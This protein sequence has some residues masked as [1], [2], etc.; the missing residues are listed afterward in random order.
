[1]GIHLIVDSCCDLTSEM[2]ASLDCDIAPLIVRVGGGCEYIDDGTVDIAALIADMAASRQGASSSCP[3]TEDYAVPMRGYDECFVVT[4][5]SKLSGSFNAARLAAEMV[6]EE[7]P[8]KKIHVFDS[9]SASSGEVHIAMYLGEKIRQ[10]LDF[11]TIVT[12]TEA[13]IDQ[14]RTLFVLEDFSNFIK[15][16]RIPKIA[17]L[18][19]SALNLCPIMGENGEGDI[20]LAA[21]ARGVQNSLHKL[22]EMVADMTKSRTSHSLRLV[23]AQCNCPQRAEEIKK[24]LL[25]KCEALREVVVVP[26]GALSAMYAGSGGVVLAF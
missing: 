17:G 13:F 22:V 20:K 24:N 7:F 12:Q 3:S 19:A 21:K 23:L 1:M 18:I 10:G 11:E 6:R 9:R 4:L 25:E 15:N 16:G 5:S 26:T 8:D 14:M 2:K